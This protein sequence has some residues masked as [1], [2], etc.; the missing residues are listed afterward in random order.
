MLVY[1]LIK[2][3]SNAKSIIRRFLSIINNHN[4]CTITLHVHLYRDIIHFITVMIP[5]LGPDNLRD[6]LHE[7]STL[8]SSY[9]SFGVALGIPVSELE[10]LKIQYSLNVEQALTDV[11]ILWL[12][13]NYPTSSTTPPT[14]R[15]LVKAVASSSGGNHYGLA[16]DIAS[17]HP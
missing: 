1:T 4:E 7:V 2:S 9:F 10:A 17:C 8:K 3:P 14:W 12:R 5:I 11:L 16:V 6:V 15:S 13:K